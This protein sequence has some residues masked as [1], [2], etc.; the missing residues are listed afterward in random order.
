MVMYHDAH[1]TAKSIG[2]DINIK[3]RQNGNRTGFNI[4]Q[5]EKYN[6][7][8]MTSS[9]ATTLYLFLRAGG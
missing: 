4:K 5:D 3:S 2:K 7:N 1:G 9:Y 8:D 6:E